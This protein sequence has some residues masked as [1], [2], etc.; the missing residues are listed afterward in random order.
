MAENTEH[1]SPDIVKHR[2]ES[3]NSVPIESVEYQGDG[4]Y[5]VR[6]EKEGGISF[7]LGP[8]D[9]YAIRHIVQS[10]DNDYLSVH[11]VEKR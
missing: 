3:H 1:T 5:H 7:A 10:T 4:K 8:M 11:I 2:L 6:I 9:R